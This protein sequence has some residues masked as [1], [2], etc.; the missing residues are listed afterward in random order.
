[1][2]YRDIWYFGVT[3]TDKSSYSRLNDLTP[4]FVWKNH[5]NYIFS[6]S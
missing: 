3:Y 1:M 6:S 2:L 4:H 5:I